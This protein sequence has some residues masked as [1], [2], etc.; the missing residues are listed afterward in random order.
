MLVRT[1]PG[2]PLHVLGPSIVSLCS[3]A[4]S[5]SYSSHSLSVWVVSVALPSCWLVLLLSS[6]QAA[7]EPVEFAEFFTS[8][9]M[10]FL[11]FFF[12]VFLL[13]FP[14]DMSFNQLSISLLNFPHCSCMLFFLFF[15]FT[16]SFIMLIIVYI[17][18]SLSDR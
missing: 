5:F 3:G 17:L 13:A 1:S 11:G 9:T 12:F 2:L 18:E 8:D 6:A 7:A 4:H 15:F 14:F 10:V 16:K